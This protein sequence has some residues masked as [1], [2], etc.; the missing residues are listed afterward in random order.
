VGREV[1]HYDPVPGRWDPCVPLAEVG[2]RL[3]TR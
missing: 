1:L 2:D 3:W